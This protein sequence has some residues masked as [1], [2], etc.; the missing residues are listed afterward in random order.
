MPRPMIMILLI[1]VFIVPAIFSGILANKF[2]AFEKNQTAAMTKLQ[3]ELAAMQA[4]L[5]ELSE[6]KAETT[7]DAETVPDHSEEIGQLQE[8]IAALESALNSL[9]S[10]TDAAIHTADF[11]YLAIGNSITLH[12][13]CD[14]WWN[15]IGMAASTQDKDYVHRVISALEAK[16]GEV[17][18]AAY[19]FATWEVQA[20]DRAQTLSLLDPYLYEQLDLVSI[21]LSE[22]AQDLTTFEKDFEELIR[23]V[24]EKA[25]KAQI[26]VVGDF[27]DANKKTVLKRTAA[28]ATGVTFVSLNDIVGDPEYQSAMG[29]IVYDPEGG[30]HE[31]DH[32]GVAGHP[33]DKGM[34]YIANAILGAMN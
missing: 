14:Y 2:S 18:S 23:Y 24:Q 13:T 34:E 33:G 27:W 5:N 26:I 15:E 11:N 10:K 25:P 20:H 9:N 32:E 4:K 22:N 6:T 3:D 29:A 1:L 31:V 19:N 17:E 7:P 28:N 21:Q 30:E 16:Y 12:E 8:K